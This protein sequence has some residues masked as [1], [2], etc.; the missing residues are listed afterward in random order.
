MHFFLEI[1][2]KVVR[3]LSNVMFKVHYKCLKLTVVCP[4]VSFMCFNYDDLRMS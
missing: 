3:I 1:M 2:L 4:V